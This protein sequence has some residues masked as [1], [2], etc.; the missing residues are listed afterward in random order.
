M[1]VK[2]PCPCCGYRTLSQRPPGTYEV[3]AVCFWEDDPQQ[4]AD[5]ELA[6]GANGVSLRQARS[7]FVE[8]GASE[9]RFLN[10][11]RSPRNDE[12]RPRGWRSSK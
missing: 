3:C 6:G 12:A 10:K 1:R 5:P 9:R 4:F 8:F 2:Y 7:N 11:V